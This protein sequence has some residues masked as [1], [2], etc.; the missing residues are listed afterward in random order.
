L[1][2]C[3]TQPFRHQSKTMLGSIAAENRDCEGIESPFILLRAI[4]T[5]AFPAIQNFFAEFKHKFIYKVL[6]N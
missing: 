5:K 3:T 2:S 1:Y 4:T 6:I